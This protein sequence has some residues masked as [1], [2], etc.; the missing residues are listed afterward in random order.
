MYIIL[1]RIQDIH[2]HLFSHSLAAIWAGTIGD[3][4]T[5]IGHRKFSGRPVPLIIFRSFLRNIPHFQEHVGKA[6]HSLPFDHHRRILPVAEPELSVNIFI[7]Q[8]RSSS[9]GGFSVDDQYLSVVSV[10]IVGG[11]HWF[12]GSEHFAGDPFFF[13]DL[14]IKVGKKGQN[15]GS[16]IHYPD[17]YPFL[18]LCLQDI[19]DA[20]P[21]FSFRNDKEFQKN[22]PLCLFQLRQDIFVLIVSQGIIFYGSMAVNRSVCILR[23]IICQMGSLRICTPEP[24]FDLWVLYHVFPGFF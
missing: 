6:F 11:K 14:R 12:D 18:R 23:Q 8:V 20:L 17:F 16:V 5:V 10:I 19:Q 7:C 2:V 21:H 22:K 1:C 24:F 3:H 15:T 9:K 4:K 13:Q